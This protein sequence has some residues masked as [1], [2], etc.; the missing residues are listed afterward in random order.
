MAKLCTEGRFPNLVF[1]LQQKYGYGRGHFLSKLKEAK[2]EIVNTG[3][4]KDPPGRFS[5]CLP[6][7]FLLESSY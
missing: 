6:A 1:A 2:Y 3:V 4:S 5:W 7:T